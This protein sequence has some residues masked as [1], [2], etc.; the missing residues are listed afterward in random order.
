MQ[1]ALTLRACHTCRS[2]DLTFTA[3]GHFNAI[4]FWFH[5]ELYAGITLSTAPEAVAAGEAHRWFTP[6]IALAGRMSSGRCI[7]T[8]K[9]IDP[10]T[11]IIKSMF[12]PDH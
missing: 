1:P 6:R 11:L 12:D 4:V 7:A 8:D 2:V 10:L 3:D 5:L 9:V